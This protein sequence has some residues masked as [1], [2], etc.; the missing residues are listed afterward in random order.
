MRHM[1]TLPPHPCDAPGCPET[2]PHGVRFC[3]THAGTKPGSAEP[4]DS[5]AARGYGR[6][7]REARELFLKKHPLCAECSKHGRITAARVVDHIVPHRGDPVLFWDESNWQPL[8]D[9]TSA[10]DCHNAKTGQGL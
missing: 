9:F 10:Y 1:P 2:V 7:W 6:K 5:A 8:C 4:R 3:D